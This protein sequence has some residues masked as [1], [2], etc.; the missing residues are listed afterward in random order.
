[1]TEHTREALLALAVALINDR[2]AQDELI[3]YGNLAAHVADA[4][5]EIIATPEVA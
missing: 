2:E 4:A 3:P 5:L 1:M